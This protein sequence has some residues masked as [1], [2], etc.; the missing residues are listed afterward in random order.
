M[1]EKVSVRVNNS[2]T[3]YKSTIHAGEHLLAADESKARGGQDAGPNPF[4]YL[5]SSLGACTCITLRMYAELK[6]MPLENVEVDLSLE[7][8]EEGTHIER[9]IRLSGALSP[10]Q[11]ERLLAIA[12][13]CPV[14]KILSGSIQISSGLQ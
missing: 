12:N 5:L 1:E 13:R 10:E 2:G 14:H 6:K 8:K 7:R 3:L 4:E 9:K 11:S